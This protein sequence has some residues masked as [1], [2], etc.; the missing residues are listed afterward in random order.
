MG[1]LAGCL[2]VIWLGSLAGCL[3]FISL[4]SL[5]GC[6]PVISLGS[7]AG[8]LLPKSL[9]SLAGCRF[10]GVT[11]V[12]RWGAVLAVTFRVLSGCLSS[13]RGGC[14]HTKAGTYLSHNL[15]SVTRKRGAGRLG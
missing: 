5:A 11:L 9:G 12:C 2:P 10:V 4:G 7:L 14:P 8:C 1:S 13:C 3:P 6:L 15:R